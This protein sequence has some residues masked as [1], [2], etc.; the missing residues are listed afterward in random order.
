MSACPIHQRVALSTCPKCGNRLSWFRPGLLECKCGASML[1]GE[2]HSISQAEASLLDVIRR[3][4]LALQPSEENPAALPQNQLLAMNLRS[5]LAV[6]RTLGRHRMIANGNPEV[7]NKKRIASEASRV[8]T[9]WPKNFIDLFMDL[10]RALPANPASGVGKQF[11]SIYTSLFKSEAI[12]PREQ[13]DFLKVAFLDFAMNHWGQGFVDHKLMKQLGATVPKRY[14]TQAEF[15]AQLG[16]RAKYR[17]PSSEGSESVFNA[18]KCG[19]RSDSRGHK[20]QFDF[21]HVARKDL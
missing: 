2:S 8:L 12:A 3:R 18:I 15:A 10:G 19:S 5:L 13:T 7:T 1:E 16:I 21:P 6:V 11:A 9:N 17:C 4:V 20:S 14:L